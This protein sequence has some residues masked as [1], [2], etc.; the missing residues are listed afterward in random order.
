MHEENNNQARFEEGDAKCNG[1]IP[2]T[3]I[4]KGR[5]NG[6]SGQDHQCGENREIGFDWSGAH[7]CLPIK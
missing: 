4:D 1:S 2:R 3:K 5:R 7:A 6:E